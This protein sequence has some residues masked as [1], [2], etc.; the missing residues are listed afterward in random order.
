[1]NNEG[2]LVSEYSVLDEIRVSNFVERDRIQ[3]LL[4][5]AVLVICSEEDG[6]AMHAVR[7]S[8]DDGKPVFAL[9][10]NKLNEID[11]YIDSNDEKQLDFVF[12]S[13]CK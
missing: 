11:N 6:G 5:K 4:T 10:G 1:M 12:N 2:L 7:R 9:I 3:S 13:M 8:L